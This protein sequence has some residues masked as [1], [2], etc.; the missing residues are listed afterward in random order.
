[1][2]YITT[3]QPMATGVLGMMRITGRSPPASS[4]SRAAVTPAAMLT[5]TGLCCCRM[6]RRAVSSRAMPWGL[7]PR[8]R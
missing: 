7:T 5:S 2:Q 6:G 4:S 1:M 8:N 3:P